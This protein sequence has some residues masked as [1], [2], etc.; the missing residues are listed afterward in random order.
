M[1]EAQLSVARTARSGSGVQ[2]GLFKKITVEEL[3]RDPQQSANNRPLFYLSSKMLEHCTIRAQVI[4]RL[5][6]PAKTR[7]HLL[8][9]PINANTK[10]FPYCHY[11]G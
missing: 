7:W 6:Q 10:S 8:C 2:V 11:R 5:R 1:G 9:L 4:R 3:A